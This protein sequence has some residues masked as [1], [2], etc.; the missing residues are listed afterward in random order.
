[1]TLVMA[2]T[3]ALTALLVRLPFFS[4]LAPVW[5]CAVPCRAVPCRAVPCRAVPC[6]AVL[7]C[8]VLCVW[9]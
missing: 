3:P 5:R 6:R 4:S 7:C 9:S 2:A 1:M 8:A